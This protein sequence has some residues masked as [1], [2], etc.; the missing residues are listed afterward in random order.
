MSISYDYYKIF[1]YVATYHSFNK[2]AS[3]LSNSQPN[4]SRS[5][6]NLENQ[7]GC[8]LFNRSSSGVTLTYAGEELFEHVKIAF[9]HLAQGENILMATSALKRGILTIGCSVSLSQNNMHEKMIPTIHAFR[10]KYPDIYLKIIHTSAPDL[11]SYV[12]NNLMDIA[13]VTTPYKESKSKN[14]SKRILFSYNEIAIAGNEFR[15]LSGRKVSLKELADYPI[16]GLGP[17]S[18]TFKYYTDVFAEYSLEYKPAFETTSNGQILV[19]ARENLGIGFLHPKDAENAIKDGQILKIDLKEKLPK[20]YVAMVCNTKENHA[21]T[22][23]EQMLMES[24]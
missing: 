16:I 2:A 24:L 8:K 14:Y 15:E 5:I 21:A 18:M 3:V 17:R 22:T 19:Y 10:K 1:Y 6:T 11:V 4:I 7:L 20:R 13:F 23:F 9:A 12:S